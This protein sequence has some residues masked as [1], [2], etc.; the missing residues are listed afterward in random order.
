[1]SWWRRLWRRLAALRVVPVGQE[2]D[3]V[4][5]P[6]WSAGTEADKP[7]G[8]LYQELL[9]ARE[10][11][12]RNPLARRLVGMVTAYVVGN[13]ITMRADYRPLDRFLRE[14]WA[15]NHMDQRVADWSDELARAGEIF[16]VLFTNPVDGMSYVRAV[17]ASL[18]DH[19]EW[20]EGDYEIEL[21]FRELPAPE[22]GRDLAEKWWHS[23]HHERAAEVQEPV[24][25]HYA[26]NRPV[27][28]IRGESDLAAILPWLRRY[29]G[30]LEDRVRLNAGVRAF[31]WIVNAPARLHGVLRERYRRPPEPG[32]IIIADES[33]RWT[34]VAPTLHANDASADGRAIRWLIAAGGP[35]TSLLDLGEGEDA[36][37]AT[38]RVMT[39]MRRRFLRRRQ[40]YL[41][42][43]L[44][45]LAVVAWRRYVTV[46]GLR[47][48]PV[49]T[50]DVVVDV[51]DI[52]VEDNRELAAAAASLAA[53]LADLAQ[54][55]GRGPAFRALALRW[56]VKFIGEELSERQLEE[57]LREHAD[58][59]QGPADGPGQAGDGEGD[60]AG[61]L[62]AR[63]NGHGPLGGVGWH[64]P[65]GPAPGHR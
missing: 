13:G 16:P 29:S 2:G 22:P 12:R 61:D 32:S 28:A 11:W 65:G 58:E 7:W 40:A 39:E 17:P 10:A 6:L 19:I 57:V 8:E 30:W 3:G 5:R 51:P 31:L 25:L 47:V 42:W 46:R 41:A 50:E 27:G 52:S 21:R 53:A 1:M 43:L 35:G 9:D 37:L 14:W 48:R 45:D 63:R 18:I 55:T 60:G 59:E 20:R 24:M 26:V 33:E 54:L 4:T 36:N 56:F 44:A 64:R 38:G 34:A 49:S 15:A 62:G 23:Q